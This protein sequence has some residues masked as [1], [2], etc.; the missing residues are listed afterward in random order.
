MPKVAQVLTAQQV[1]SIKKTGQHAVG[2]VPGLCLQVKASN[3][4]HVR[5][6]RSWLLRYTFAGKRKNIGLGAYDQLLLSEAR[7]AARMAL[8]L[9]HQGVDPVVSRKAAKLKLVN[10]QIKAKTF[11]ECARDYMAAHLPK[12]RNVKHQKQWESTLTPICL[13]KNR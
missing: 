10:D 7:E 4:T 3:Q 8:R 13:P 2:G 11:K 6:S 5:I 9:L 1:K 12:H